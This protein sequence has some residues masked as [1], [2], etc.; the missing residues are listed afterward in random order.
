MGWNGQSSV[1]GPRVS[2]LPTYPLSYATDA[3]H[4]TPQSLHSHL[5]PTFDMSGDEDASSDEQVC[6]SLSVVVTHALTIFS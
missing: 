4:S 3:F 2:S 5:S 6:L 1:D